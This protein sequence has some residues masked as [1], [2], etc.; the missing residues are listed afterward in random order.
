[1]EPLEPLESSF[2]INPSPMTHYLVSCNLFAAA[3]DLWGK[4]AGGEPA[5][6]EKGEDGLNS[7]SRLN[8]LNRN[9]GGRSLR[10]DDR[11][12]DGMLI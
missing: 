8:S 7:L 6:G 10:W 12:G 9:A 2:P 1:L 5:D 3:C 4:K 11:D